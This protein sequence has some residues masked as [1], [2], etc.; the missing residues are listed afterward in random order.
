MSKFPELHITIK[1]R[2]DLVGKPFE[3]E[4][5]DWDTHQ[6]L[7]WGICDDLPELVKSVEKLVAGW[8]K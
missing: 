3:I 4:V 8:Q 1:K 6:R 7:A 5:A 2:P